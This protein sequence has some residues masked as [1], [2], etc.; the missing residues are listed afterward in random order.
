M[1]AS[2][3][4][5]APRASHT[6]SITAIAVLVVLAA[7]YFP[8][9]LLMESPDVSE[10]LYNASYIYGI[11]LQPLFAAV[12]LAVA[13][14]IG[15]KQGVGRQWFFLGVGVA[16]YAIG[17]VLWMIFEL[18][19]N[20][21]PYPSAADLFYSAEYIFFLLAIALAVIGYRQLVKVTAPLVAGG[22]VA[23]VGVGVIYLLLLKPYIFPDSAG[24]ELL[25]GTLYP[26]GDVVFMLAPAVTLALVVGQLGA[27][28]LA[29]PWWFVVAG[30]LVFALA[31]SFYTYA[32]WAGTGLTPAM[33]M[34]WITANMLFAVA[35]LVARDV[36][37][38]R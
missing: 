29:R 33:D 36:Y 11:L 10:A 23:L 15:L 19:L 24:L 30:A 26:V 27:G 18:V 22:V 3:P 34:G 7:L 25:V 28:R 17:D 5:S 31:D 1:S 13:A 12:I 21:D 16:M 4:A 38:V 2:N 9:R 32:D 6:S 37:R 14:G 20:I 35:A 8:L